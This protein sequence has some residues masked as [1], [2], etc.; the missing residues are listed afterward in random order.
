MLLSSPDLAAYFERIGFPSPPGEPGGFHPGLESLVSLHRAHA[1]AIPFENLAIHR[2]ELPIRLDLPSLVDKLIHRKRGGYCFEQ[3]SLFLAVLRTLG[4]R[5]RAYEARVRMGASGV[6]PRT[7]MVLQVEVEDGTWLADVGFGGDGL[8]EP[9]PLDGREVRHGFRTYRVALERSEEEPVEGGAGQLKTLQCLGLPSCDDW[10]DLY[11][12]EPRSVQP[13]DMELANWFTSTHPESIFVKTRRSP[14]RVAGADLH[15]DTRK[16]GSTSRGRGAGAGGRRGGRAGALRGDR[17]ASKR[18]KR[19]SNRSGDSGVMAY[20]DGPDFI[21]IQFRGGETYL[22][23][24]PPIRR[25]KIEKMKELAVQGRG[26]ATFI[27]QNPD[28]RDGYRR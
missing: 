18:M 14:L 7:H 27:N 6:L 11:A 13:V 12:I 19:Y 25:E 9:V 2:G 22:Y 5:A 15:H 28:V 21:R 8:L 10:I 17:S 26:L 1:L 4:F 24:S 20:E 3:N 16:G 23:S